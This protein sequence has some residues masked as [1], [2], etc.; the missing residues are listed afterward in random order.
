MTFAS[1]DLRFDCRRAAVG[2]PDSDPL[3]VGKLHL[4]I[5]DDPLSGLADDAGI[6]KPVT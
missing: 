5:H 2:N 3:G 6:T 1:N 4:A